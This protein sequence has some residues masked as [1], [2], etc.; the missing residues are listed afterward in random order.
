MTVKR[1]VSRSW[2]NP[3]PTVIWE[4][5][6]EVTV[7]WQRCN[8]TE[9]RLLIYVW[10]QLCCSF[11]CHHMKA[12]YILQLLLCNCTPPSKM[13]ENLGHNSWPWSSRKR[14]SH[15]LLAGYIFS[16]LCCFSILPGSGLQ[17]VFILRC[18]STSGLVTASD[19]KTRMSDQSFELE[20]LFLG[21]SPCCH[22]SWFK[23]SNQVETIELWI[24]TGPRAHPV[25]PVSELHRSASRAL[26]QLHIVVQVGKDE[27]RPSVREAARG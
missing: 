27:G 11:H 16:A 8:C 20:Y 23:H 18:L 25:L 26:P 7:A 12:W 3:L 1:V 24:Q 14:L 2:F 13:F 5:F 19:L 9:R 17:D 21:S 4:I 6:R 10:S 15:V 22:W